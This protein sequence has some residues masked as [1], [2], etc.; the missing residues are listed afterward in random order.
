M[1]MGGG[2]KNPDEK[3]L[4]KNYVLVPIHVICTTI[5]VEGG[6]SNSDGG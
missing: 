5:I 2:G 6:L 3:I 4:M 1:L